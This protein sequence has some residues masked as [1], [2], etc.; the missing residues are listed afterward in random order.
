M[1]IPSIS[2]ASDTLPFSPPLREDMGLNTSS[3][4]NKNAARVF[5]ICVSHDRYFIDRTATRVL[6]L[7]NKHFY[8]FKGGYSYY[9]EK[10][11]TVHGL[12]PGGDGVSQGSS[13]TSDSQGGQ[14]SADPH[15]PASAV[16][17]KKAW[18][19]EKEKETKKRRI[20]KE[21]DETE[22]HI[23]ELENS[24]SEIEEKMLS[25]ELV[26]D[27]TALNELASQKE[28]LESELADSMDHWESLAESLE[29]L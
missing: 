9:L 17:S 19:A 15:D 21:Y 1:D 2:L 14:T 24:I 28:A 3:P 23:E 11:D 6:E 29:E 27:Y 12:A 26:T 22:A 7:H 5:L 13:N 16:S 25:P 8:D 4:I 20:Q 10:K 18:L